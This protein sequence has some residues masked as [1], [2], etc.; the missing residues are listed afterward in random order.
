MRASRPSHAAPRYAAPRVDERRSSR[1]ESAP[2]RADRSSRDSRRPRAAAD[3]RGVEGDFRPRA[4]QAGTNAAFSD[5]IRKRFRSVKAERAYDRTIGKRERERARADAPEASRAAVYEMR[6]GGMHRKS[7]R[8]QT[9]A[10]ERSSF[11]FSISSL[12]SAFASPSQLAVRALAVTVVVAFVCVMLYP[13]CANYYNE[14]RHLQQLQAEYDELVSYNQEMQARVDYLNTDEGI[15]DRARSD[16]GLMR[17]DEH[18]AT[19][20]GVTVTPTDTDSDD[21]AYPVE[22]GDV[23]AP[24]TWYSGILDV[25]FGY[26]K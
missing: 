16:L 26:G 10:K 2:R 17:K 19:V 21:I 4:R 24:S 18:T 13:P 6:M 8:M 15:E 23:A 5:E 7:A 12:L 25:V 11:G 20:E 1:V 9:S 14:T 3:R 22:E